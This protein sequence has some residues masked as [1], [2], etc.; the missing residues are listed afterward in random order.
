[1]RQLKEHI[2]SK[3]LKK[4]WVAE[5]LGI[6]NVYLSLILK[7]DKTPSLDLER[8]IKEFIN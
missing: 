7:G 3:G 4:I 5:Q 8:K 2:K 6:T 1:M